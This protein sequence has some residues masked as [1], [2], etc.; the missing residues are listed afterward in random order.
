MDAPAVHPRCGLR[1]RKSCAYLEREGELPVCAHPGALSGERGR[2]GGAQS[3]RS[4]LQAAVHSRAETEQ[5]DGSESNEWIVYHGV[6]LSCCLRVV[7]RLVQSEEI[8]RSDGRQLSPSQVEATQS[9]TL[10]E[11][12]H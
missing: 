9:C 7:A 1:R 6:V 11:S 2:E 5:V 4:A 10:K 3:E 12:H 8:G